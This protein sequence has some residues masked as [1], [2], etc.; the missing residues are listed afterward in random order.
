MSKR[1]LF[2][3]ATL[4]SIAGDGF[5]ASSNIRVVDRP[6]TA[7]GN[8][9]YVGNR[10]PARSLSCRSAR[11]GRKAGSAGSSNCRRTDSTGT[12]QR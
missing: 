5:C 11:S 3:T 4:I 7:G 2:I 12:S 8:D 10:G 1:V 9:F 6:I